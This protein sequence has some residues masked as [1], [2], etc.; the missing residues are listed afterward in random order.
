MNLNHLVTQLSLVIK[1]GN[2]KYGEFC[3]IIMFSD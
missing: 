3:R 1:Q 2:Y